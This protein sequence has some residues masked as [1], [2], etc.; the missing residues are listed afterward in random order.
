[1]T[2]TQSIN[3]FECVYIQV[4]QLM[5]YRYGYAVKDED[6]NDFNQ[7]EQSDGQQVEHI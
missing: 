5:P 6:G 4:P 7:Q 1:M 2:D 3:R